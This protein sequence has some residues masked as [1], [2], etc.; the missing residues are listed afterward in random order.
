MSLW[1][2]IAL[3]LSL[4]LCLSLFPS[5]LPAQW[6]QKLHSRL[7]QPSAQGS[8]S[9]Q[10]PVRGFFLGGLMHWHFS[11]CPKSLLLRLSYGLSSA[12]PSHSWHMRLYFGR[13]TTGDSGALVIPALAPKV[14]VPCQERQAEKTQSYGLSSATWS[15]LTQGYHSERNTSLS[16]PT[17]G[18]QPQRF[19]LGTEAD[20][21]TDRSNLFPK[22]LTLSATEWR[23]SSLRML[24]K[25]KDGTSLVASG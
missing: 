6:R 20:Y 5:L 2:R 13:D 23:S 14:V 10:F 8:L 24:S 21:K 7:V 3:S 12:Q 22:E 18:V 15:T 1:A 19:C 9:H 16:P 25:Q 4:S 11:S 17:A